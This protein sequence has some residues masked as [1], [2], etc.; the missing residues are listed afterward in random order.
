MKI[1]PKYLKDREL[2][3]A[4]SKY[5]NPGEAS[6]V[7]RLYETAAGKRG[8]SDEA[9]ELLSLNQDHVTLDIELANMLAAHDRHTD[10]KPT[11]TIVHADTEDQLAELYEAATPG[12]LA[13]NRRPGRSLRIE[14]SL[15]MSTDSKEG[16]SVWAQ[17]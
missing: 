14:D 12:S 5:S 3:R 15:A 16:V 4:F 11:D 6:R 13:L 10:A 2:V 17:A 8:L 7:F 1:L 9:L